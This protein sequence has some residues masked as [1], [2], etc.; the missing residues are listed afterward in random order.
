VVVGT[1]VDTSNPIQNLPKVLPKWFLFPFLLVVIMGVVANN[2]MNSYSSGLSLLALGVKIPRYKS[3]FIDAVISVSAASVA[4]FIYN[5]STVFTNFLGLLVILLSPWA[6]IFLVDYLLRR[7]TYA[8]D[9]LLRSRGG[10]YWYSRGIGWRGIASL[11]VGVGAAAC[12]ANTTYFVGFI[13][14]ALGGADISPF[15]GFFLGSV[16]Y[17]ALAKSEI[18]K[19]NPEPQA[20]FAMKE[21]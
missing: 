9:D 19:P 6:G 8:S 20:I 21:S 11:V 5:F 13:S 2:V 12:S 14:K 16:L 18:Q 4:L 1:L 10:L 17:Y 3:V 15:V 7:G